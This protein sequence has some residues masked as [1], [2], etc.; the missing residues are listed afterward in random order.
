MR[1]RLT[2]ALPLRARAFGTSG[3]AAVHRSQYVVNMMAA[4]QTCVTPSH[5]AHAF[6]LEMH[7]VDT[8][9]MG[10]SCAA[11]RLP[12]NAGKL[13]PL[14]PEEPNTATFAFG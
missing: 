11:R 2:A 14:L 6:S 3:T 4:A 9:T 7:F 10:A 1:V 5:T 12:Q 8:D 13:C